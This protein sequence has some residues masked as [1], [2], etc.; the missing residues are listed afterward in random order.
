SRSPLSPDQTDVLKLLL[1]V[2][3]QKTDRVTTF[4]LSGCLDDHA[5]HGFSPKTSLDRICSHVVW[6]TTFLAS[7][8]TENGYRC[9]E[10]VQRPKRLWLY[11]AGQWWAGRIC[12]HKR[13][14]A[15]GPSWI[16]RR[17]EGLLRGKGRSE[18]RKVE[19]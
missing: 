16:G 17:A 10:V 1:C 15:C 4:E 3:C 19:C 14:R 11:S 5:L 6:A 9:C 13:R 7:M 2:F 12:S 8:E 18:A